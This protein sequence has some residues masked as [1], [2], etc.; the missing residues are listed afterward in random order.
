MCKLTD[1]MSL[2][3]TVVINTELSIDM[4]IERVYPL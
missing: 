1:C 3:V 4:G 2:I